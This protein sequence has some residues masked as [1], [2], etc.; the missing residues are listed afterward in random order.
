MW[1]IDAVRWW[2][3]ETDLPGKRPQDHRPTKGGTP[4]AEWPSGAGLTVWAIYKLFGMSSE[5]AARTLVQGLT[6]P[7]PVVGGGQL[8]AVR[9]WTPESVAKWASQ[10]RGTKALACWVDGT[11]EPRVELPLEPGKVDLGGVARVLGIPEASAKWY[12]YNEPSFPDE[13]PLGQ[14]DEDDVVFWL[15]LDAPAKIRAKIESQN[16]PS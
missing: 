4:L 15:Q 16:K 14:W 10:N 11:W 5:Q 2:Y 1:S 8:T 3:D 7:K 13:S 9:R 12:A 6:F